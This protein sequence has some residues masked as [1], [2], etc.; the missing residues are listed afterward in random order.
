MSTLL[1]VQI[2]GPATQ[3]LH[4]M[5]PHTYLRLQLPVLGGRGKPLGKLD[6]LERDPDTGQLTALVVQHGMFRKRRTQVPANRVKWVNQDSVILNFTR[7]AF[8]RLPTG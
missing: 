6:A 4:D 3:P 7:P 1:N 5:D 8:K 2:P